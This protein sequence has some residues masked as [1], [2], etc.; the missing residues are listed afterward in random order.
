MHNTKSLQTRRGYRR[1]LKVEISS[2]MDSFEEYYDILFKTYSRAGQ[3]LQNI[4]FFRSA[5][6]ELGKSNNLVFFSAYYNFKLVGFRIA[7]IFNGIMHDWYA[8]DLN[9]ARDKYTN[10]ILVWEALKWGNNNNLKLFDFGGAGEPGK[11]YGVREFKKK[12]GGKLV[13]YG[14]FLKIHQSIKYNI[15]KLMLPMYKFYKK[16]LG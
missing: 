4:S 13:S 10:D 16:K 6:E 7:L 8:G 5:I 12:F 11:E 3:P 15:L 2:G 1:C 14:N 9:E